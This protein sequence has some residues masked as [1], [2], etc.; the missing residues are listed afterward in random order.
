MGGTAEYH[1]EQY[2]K[3]YPELVEEIPRNLY[4]DDIIGGGESV[5]EVKEFKKGAIQVFGEAKFELHK[6]HSNGP[7]LEFDNGVTNLLEQTY[8]KM[9]MNVQQDETIILGLFWDKS[10][11]MAGVCLT[12][13]EIVCTKRGILQYL[14]SVYDPLRL[15]SPVLLLG[16]LIF[17]KPVI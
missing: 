9:Q 2:K 5:S 15:V 7:E 17:Q 1:L 10:K 16:K 6:W 3:K 8:A 12:E 11:D 4:V 13:K 14:A